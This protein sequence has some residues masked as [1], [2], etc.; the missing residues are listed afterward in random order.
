M[1][2]YWSGAVDESPRQEFFYFSDDG[3]LVGMRYKRWKAVFAEQRAHSFDVWADP[4]VQLRVPKIFDLYSDPF[5]E[6]EHESI[7]YKDWWFRH[8]FLLVP[9]QT[10]VG[11]FLATFQQYPPRQKPASF[12][13]DQVLENMQNAAT[14]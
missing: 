10:Y 13:I 2:P 7:H 8:V 3:N 4:F 1:L 6:A 9:A 11:Q 5:E 14:Q 12:S